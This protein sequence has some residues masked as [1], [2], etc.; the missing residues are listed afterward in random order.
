MVF[1]LSFSGCR[2]D[3]YADA[4]KYYET[5][6]KFARSGKNMHRTHEGE[7]AADRS[8]T[9]NRKGHCGVRLVGDG[10]VAF[11]YH[12]TDVVTFHKDNSV[13]VHM[14]SSVSTGNF[15]NELL[16]HG[17]HLQPLKNIVWTF[18]YHLGDR[19]ERGYEVCDKCTLRLVNDETADVV[20]RV[21]G[22]AGKID[23]GKIDCAAA[24]KAREK[25][26]MVK[27]F[28]M[29]WNALQCSLDGQKI[30]REF[31]RSDEHNLL[32]LV[33]DRSNWMRIAA[34]ATNHRYPYGWN[35]GQGV[36]PVS[37]MIR[38]IYRDEQVYVCTELDFVRSYAGLKNAERMASLAWG[39]RY[40]RR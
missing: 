18:R 33:E 32:E 24:K 10:S 35:R 7:R 36:N 4:L 40:H 23:S 9:G 28:A 21:V 8:D 6:D 2:C 16:P 38:Q 34:W 12:G 30:N 22:G 20:W 13:E 5:A 26:P 31:L 3:S 37:R 15:A 11:R 29:W 1:S 25:Y 39:A 14:Y 19:A 27:E 17:V